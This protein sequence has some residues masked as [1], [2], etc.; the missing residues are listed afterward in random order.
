MKVAGRC[1][2]G[3]VADTANTI[4]PSSAGWRQAAVA[5]SV[6]APAQ[7]NVATK[8]VHGYGKGDTKMG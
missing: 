8:T 4:V 3:R 1:A 5:V 7:A 2:G 6:L